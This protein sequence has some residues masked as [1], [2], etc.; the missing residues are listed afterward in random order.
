VEQYKKVQN[1]EQEYT[2]F[3]IQQINKGKMAVIFSLPV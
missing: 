2:L 3:K 1:E